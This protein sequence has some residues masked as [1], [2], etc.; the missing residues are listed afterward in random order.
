MITLF[1]R[2]TFKFLVILEPV[3]FNRT[4]RIAVVKLISISFI[5][6][7]ISADLMNQGPSLLYLWLFQGKECHYQVYCFRDEFQKNGGHWG[8]LLWIN[9]ITFMNQNFVTTIIGMYVLKI[10]YNFGSS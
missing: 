4:A 9:N 2:V 5:L 7:A 8:K 6:R 1:C 10:Y 3:G